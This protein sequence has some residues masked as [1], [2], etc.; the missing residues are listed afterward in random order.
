M[1]YNNLMYTL[2]NDAEYNGG[3]VTAPSLYR[4]GDVQD[5]W[6][7]VTAHGIRR[8][9]KMVIDGNANWWE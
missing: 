6:D 1:K 7:A 3:S 5:E 4:I 9:K 2:K 8:I